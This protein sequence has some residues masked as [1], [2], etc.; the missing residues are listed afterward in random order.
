[1]KTFIASLVQK[2]SSKHASL[3]SRGEFSSV[4][5]GAINIGCVL[6]HSKGDIRDETA[7]GIGFFEIF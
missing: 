1:M 7:G 3:S 4:R 6:E 2:V 5:A